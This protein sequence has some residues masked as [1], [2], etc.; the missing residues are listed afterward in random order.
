[1]KAESCNSAKSEQ[2]RPVNSIRQRGEKSS[3][4]ERRVL[5]LGI[6]TASPLGSFDH[7]SE[8]SPVREKADLVQSVES[9]KSPERNPEGFKRPRPLQSS[10]L[11]LSGRSSLRRPSSQRGRFSRCWTRRMARTALYV[12]WPFCAR[13]CPLRR[14]TRGRFAVPT[15]CCGVGGLPWRVWTCV[16]CRVVVRVHC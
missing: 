6:V 4:S 7:S 1:M 14:G 10:Q 5:Q 12:H 3:E 11:T 8:T 2:V 9:E 13:L 16:L 15:W